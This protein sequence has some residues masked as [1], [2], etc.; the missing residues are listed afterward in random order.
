MFGDFRSYPALNAPP[1]TPERKV[2]HSPSLKNSLGPS[3]FLESRTA[4][5]S[6][7]SATAANSAN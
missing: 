7:S 4:I 2:S 3:G 6:T 1:L 5:S